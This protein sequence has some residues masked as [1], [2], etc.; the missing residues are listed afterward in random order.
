MS[1]IAEVKRM[2]GLI[3]DWVL[4]DNSNGL[5]D[6]VNIVRRLERMTCS[7]FK[8]TADFHRKVSAFL[9]K[10]DNNGTELRI[11]RKDL[12]WTLDRMG[13][14]LGVSRQFVHQMELSRKPLNDK[15]LELIGQKP[16]SPYTEG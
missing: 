6:R 7:D 8:D 5:Q 1:A 4:P 10:N 12:G 9:A 11:K 13:A 2:Y 15:A 14:Y 16:I 3:R